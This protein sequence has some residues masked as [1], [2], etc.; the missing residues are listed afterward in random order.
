[1]RTGACLCGAVRVRAEVGP[2]IQA[3]HCGQCQ[4]WT[5][6]GPLWSVR[7]T[8]LTVTGGDA[9]RT[10]RMSDWGERAFCGTCGSTLWWRMQG[11]PIAYVVAGLLD[12]Q[13][14]LTVDQEIFVDHRP[15]WLPPF[16]GASQSTEAEELAAL[17][18]HLEGERG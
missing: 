16:A 17:A 2:G 18:K 4:R 10:F 6:G 9:V 13:S 7:A 8:D 1:M 14:G 15:G 11:R 12:D 5:G 3:C